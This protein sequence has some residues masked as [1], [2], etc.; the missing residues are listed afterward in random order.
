MSSF[1]SASTVSTSLFLRPSSFM[2]A[3]DESTPRTSAATSTEKER[4]NSDIEMA[5]SYKSL[6]GKK[7][8]IFLKQFS[9]VLS[10]P[11][12]SE[13]NKSLSRLSYA[14]AGIPDSGGSAAS[15]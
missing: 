14:A 4:Q 5:E 6:L 9:C 15:G 10:M 8:S 13:S 3:S 1:T 11:S 2:R 7:K 12:F